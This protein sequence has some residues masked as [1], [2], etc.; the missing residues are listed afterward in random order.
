PKAYEALVTLLQ[1]SNDAAQRGKEALAKLDRGADAIKKV[2]FIGGYV[3]DP[4]GL[5]VRPKAERHRR[6]YAER[7]LFEPGRAVLTAGGRERL[8]EA[9]PWL[10]G[11]RHTGSDIVVAAYADPKGTGGPAAQAITRQQ[12]EAVADYLKTKHRAQKL[13]D[14]GWFSGSRKVTPLGQGGA[15]P[16]LP[17]ESPLP[18]ARVEVLL[19]VPQG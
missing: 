17:E 6:V 18:P 2:P 1:T 15:A 19:F 5:L 11:L 8:D 3:E 14:W 16:P 10:K 12:A 7:D 9:G 4:T 13:G